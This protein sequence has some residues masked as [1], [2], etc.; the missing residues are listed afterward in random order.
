MFAIFGLVVVRKP[1]WLSN[2][3]QFAKELTIVSL[4][5]QFKSTVKGQPLHKANRKGL[6][7]ATP[8]K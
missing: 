3:L 5:L 2:Y 7:H 8:K 4:S 1:N 6:P